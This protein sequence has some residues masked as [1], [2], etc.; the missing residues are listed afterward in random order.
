MHIE[1]NRD[2]LPPLNVGAPRTSAKSVTTEKDQFVA[3]TPEITSR[4]RE[5]EAD[6]RPD[7]VARGKQLLEN[8]EYPPLETV[9]RIASLLGGAISEFEPTRFLKQASITMIPSPAKTYKT[10]SL[11]TAS[12]VELV[13]RMYEGAIRFLEMAKLGF[14]Y[15][16]TR[17]N[18][19]RPS[20]TTSPVLR[21][22]LTN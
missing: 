13:I 18:K 16:R 1:P 8:V 12:Q 2:P 6:V 17:S 21:K 3:S 5:A 22:S 11:Q 15:S 14:D 19:S 20:I 7:M 4:V 10:I 9:G